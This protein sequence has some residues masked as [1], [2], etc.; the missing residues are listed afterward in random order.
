M[1]LCEK[2]SASDRTGEVC[3]DSKAAPIGKQLNLAPIRM[4]EG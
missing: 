3:S 4:G 2:R 1:V